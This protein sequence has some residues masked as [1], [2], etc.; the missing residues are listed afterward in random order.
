VRT[1]LLMRHAKSSWDRAELA[2]HDRPL[3]RRG[4]RDAR[5]MGALLRDQRLVPDLICV[6]TAIRA[7]ETVDLM[8]GEFS[9]KATIQV[10]P[11]LYGAS[12]DELVCQIARLPVEVERALL[13]AHNPGVEALVESLAGQWQRMPTGAIAY[14]RMRIDGW[15]EVLVAPRGDVVHVWRPRDLRPSTAP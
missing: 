1:L 15:S 2:D 8:V 13:V 11:E 7:R 3:N 9:D 4:R 5:M 6:S 12:L 14:L 10:L